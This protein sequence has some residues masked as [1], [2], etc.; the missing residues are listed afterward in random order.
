[1]RRAL[2]T[3]IFEAWGDSKGGGGTQDERNEVERVLVAGET[4]SKHCFSGRKIFL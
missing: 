4:V 2:A 3:I 1:M